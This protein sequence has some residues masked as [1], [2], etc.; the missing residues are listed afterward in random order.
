MIAY[1]CVTGALPF[2][3]ESVGDVLVKICTAP[4][5]VPSMTVPGLPKAFDGWLSRALERDPAHRFAS[6]VELGE[7]LALA[8]GISARRSPDESTLRGGGLRATIPI[9]P[10]TPTRTEGITSAPFVASTMPPRSSRGV[11]VAVLA[12]AL[13]GGTVGVLA[14]ARLM[15]AKPSAHAPVAAASGPRSPPRAKCH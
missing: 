7:A 14:V 3:G 4:P 2:E 11:V 6:A 1:K 9:V 10:L 5:P 13:V 12:A 15:A 8:A